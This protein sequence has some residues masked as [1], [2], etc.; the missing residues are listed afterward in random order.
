MTE[1][2]ALHP[3]SPLPADIPRTALVTGAGRGIGRAVALGLAADGYAVALLGRTQEHL[4][5]VAEEI[6]DTARVRTAAVDVTDADAVRR[7]VEQVADALGGIGL[8]VNNAGVIEEREVR[9]AE[10]DVQDMWRVVETN[11]RGPLNLAHAV[12]PGMVARGGGR[13]VNVNSGAAYRPLGSGTGYGISKAALARLTAL[14]H[15][16]YRDQ[17]ITVFDVAPGVVATDMT[18]AMDVHA[19]RTDWT[20]ATAT[21]DLVRAVGAGTLDRLSGRFLRA[22]VNTAADLVARTYEILVADARRLRL[23]PYGPQDPIQS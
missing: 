15:A 10:D 22:D 13:M 12:L 18:A 3:T 5:A 4:D 6:G 9:L 17:G 20:P 8:V 19:D 23:L 2:D 7:A 14:V 11:V 16:Q 21:V 1:N